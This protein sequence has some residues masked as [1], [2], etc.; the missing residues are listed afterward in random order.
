MK[1]IPLY[2]KQS[3][4]SGLLILSGA[5]IVPAQQVNNPTDNKPDGSNTNTNAS[6]DYPGLFNL[7]NTG[8]FNYV[9]TRI[10][11][12]PLS[13]L[14]PAGYYRQSTSYYDGLGRPLQTVAKQAHEDGY[15]LIQPYVYDSLGRETYTYLPYAY[16]LLTGA[17]G[18]IKV[19]VNSQLRGFYDHNGPDE[20]PYGETE[21]EAS[22]LSR[23][24]KQMSPGESWVGSS[25]GVQQ[26]QKA[27]GFWNCG[28]YTSGIMLMATAYNAYPRWTIGNNPGDIP[29]YAGGYADGQ[30]FITET[31]DEDGKKSF[32]CRDKQGRTVIKAA[33]Y[34]PG[35]FSGY[36]DII[37]PSEYAYTCYV[38][39]DL[40]RLRFA[41]PP[42]AMIASYSANP[43][44]NGNRTYTWSLVANAVEH[45]CYKYIYDHRSRLVEK[46]IPGKEPEYYVYDKR[47][48]QVMYQDG[49]MRTA[50]QWLL[51]YYDAL[52]RP[53]MSSVCSSGDSR[54]TMAGYLETPGS[55]AAPHWLYYLN[56]YQA[57][58]TYP[59]T[60]TGNTI[61][62]YTY[63]DDYSQLSAYS[64]DPTH[65]DN[66]LP[67]AGQDYLV[68]PQL[69]PVARGM[70]TGTKIKVLDPDN[71]GLNQ[72]LTTVSYYDSKGRVIQTQSQNHLGGL[73]KLS[74]VYFFQGMPWKTIYSHHNPYA[75][76]IPG[77]TDSAFH[78]Q[79]LVKIFSRNL[80]QG[81]GGNDLVY[82]SEQRINGG[83]N[84]PLAYYGYDHMNRNVLKQFPVGVVSMAYNMRGFL[85]EI[86]YKSAN[87]NNPANPANDTLFRENL[88]Y[89]KGFASK[90]YNGNIA[91]ITWNGADGQK[92]AY[93]YSYDKQNRLTHAEFREFAGNNWGQINLDYTAS[94][95]TYD[96]NGNILS[97][98]QRGVRPTG[99]IIDIDKL[100][101]TYE[102]NSNQLIKVTD[103]VAPGITQN[104]PDFKDE[105]NDATEYTYDKNGNMSLDKNKG[106]TAI[107]Y[108][109]LNKP[110][111]ITVSGKGSITYMYDAAGNRLQKRVHDFTGSGS[112]K[113]YDYIGNFVYEDTVLQYILNEEGRCRPV[114]NSETN[115]LTQYV[116]DYFIKDHL[117]NV[118]S[119]VTATPMN[120]TYLA[121]HE[122]VSAN[123]EQLVFDNIPNVRG[124]TP[125]SMDPNDGMAAHLVANDP[126]TR[127]GTAI[128]L[129]TMPGDRFQISARS[130]YEGDPQPDNQL[131][132][133]QMLE[134][135]FNTLTGGAN[136]DGVPVQ[137]I[138]EHFNTL[139]TMFTQPDLLTNFDLVPVQNESDDAPRAYLNVLFFDEFMTLLPAYSRR[140]QAGSNGAGMAQWHNLVSSFESMDY[141]GTRPKGYILVFIDNEEIGQDVWFD[142]L[143][144]GHY[145][146]EVLEEN[147]YYPFGLTLTKSAAGVK[148]QP[149]RYNGKELETN[150]DLQFYEYGARQ[151]NAQIGRWNGVDPLADKYYAISPFAYVDN[152]PVK[153]IDP[154][155]KE[156]Q[157]SYLVMGKFKPEPQVTVTYKSG[158]LYNKDG[159]KY[160][161]DNEY[162][163]GTQ[164][165][166][167]SLKESGG[168]AGGIV[169]HLEQSSNTHSIANMD[170]HDNPKDVADPDYNLNNQNR[171]VTGKSESTI[172]KYTRNDQTKRF[173]PSLGKSE[174]VTRTAKKGLI[175]EL[176]HAFGK[177]IKKPVDNE[178]NRESEGRS[179]A[180]E[181]TVDDGS[182]KRYTHGGNVYNEEDLNQYSEEVK[183]DLQTNSNRPN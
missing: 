133:S 126:N 182:A 125:G 47:D 39:D 95:I 10:P 24:T 17:D 48:R 109:Y 141:L 35:P 140:I 90:L 32:E 82:L 103:Q 1:I 124:G 174:T 57:Y 93:G 53:Y 113:V 172:T 50:N 5:T 2:I 25:R 132:A 38:Y 27:N 51:T 14:S 170:I 147:H 3:L 149:Y 68:H 114:A 151:Y 70:V 44:P 79:K 81:G 75:K 153:F 84:Y 173:N 6:V 37:T 179:V 143:F 94:N 142:D 49:N 117:G 97:M 171:S 177:D 56:N 96:L 121:Q 107:T 16:K 72:W 135:V 66:E 155:G 146:S 12:E 108:N 88:Y 180:V 77:A 116:Y 33:Q 104:L 11:D 29:V 139:S 181:N 127:V 41:I 76:I 120:A 73:E 163:R 105:A 62:S 156:I 123:I 138:P 137:D 161:G 46:K 34:L 169:E 150:F 164:S 80:K 118:R 18:K 158:E 13:S 128:L 61:L 119:T 59:G 92:K 134:S 71:P 85:K 89:D 111:K 69:N 54:S 26:N 86:V 131:D 8:K 98:Y 91:G 167:N 129:Q 36:P 42:K 101:Y 7:H 162:L 87:A 28:W 115:Y 22:P 58:N 178:S 100:A 144:V 4:L 152:N 166:L 99:G 112:L 20:Q 23:V 102:A 154:N 160:T 9:R 67:G 45:L 183:K 74:T 65:F 148:A 159:T 165:D 176:T 157:I 106:I 43:S 52:D 168:I 30:L 40:G 21:F 55:Y 31:I 145:T 63:Y 83:I 130:F 64:Y 110:E 122:L 19:N 136:Y 175:H 78:H 15:D 60:I